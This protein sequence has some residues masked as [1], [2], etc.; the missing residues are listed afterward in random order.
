MDVILVALISAFVGLDTKTV[1]I[2][3]AQFSPVKRYYGLYCVRVFLE[4]LLAMVVAI[5]QACA[6][7]QCS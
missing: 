5:R 4:S 6:D 1:P 3:A 7:Q 2:V